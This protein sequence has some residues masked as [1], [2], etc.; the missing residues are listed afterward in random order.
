MSFSAQLLRPVYCL[1]K[2]AF[3]RTAI[4]RIELDGTF[5]FSTDACYCIW[6][7]L[8]RIGRR[9]NWRLIPTADLIQR[10]QR[11]R[12]LID[13]RVSIL[14]NWQRCPRRSETHPSDTLARR[15]E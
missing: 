8:G 12:G 13:H 15:I 4:D 2:Q 14:E 11:H 3:S 5:L 9:L 1:V 6:I 7:W 10:R